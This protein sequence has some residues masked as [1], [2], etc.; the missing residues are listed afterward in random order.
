MPRVICAHAPCNLFV[1]DGRR[2]V[3]PYLYEGGLRKCTY[4]HGA[5]EGFRLSTRASK[6]LP[7]KSIRAHGAAAQL[8]YCKVGK[9]A[10][11]R[12]PPSCTPATKLPRRRNCFRGW[13]SPACSPPTALSLSLLARSSD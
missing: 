9:T 5:T 12:T 3:A 13:L 4:H 11:S 10:P 6:L 7:S 1:F 2:K 8:L